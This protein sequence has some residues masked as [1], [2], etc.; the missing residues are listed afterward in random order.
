M[1]LDVEQYYQELNE[2]G[3]PE[4]H[5]HYIGF[6]VFVKCTSIHIVVKI[7]YYNRLSVFVMQTTYIDWMFGQTRM[8]LEKG[9]KDMIEYFNHCLMSAGLDGYMDAFANK[10][11]I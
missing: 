6:Q 9:V 2:K 8:V 7:E 11:G 5:T 10:Y 3:V 4:H 1:L